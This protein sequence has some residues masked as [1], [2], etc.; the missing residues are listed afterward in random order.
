MLIAL[1]L[2]FAV[3]S[4]GEEPA[5]SALPFQKYLPPE[6]RL[7]FDQAVAR[8]LAQ[9]PT[10]LNAALEV[11]RSSALVEQARAT[12]FPTLFG[13]GT[14]TRLDHDRSLPG[15]T[16]EETRILVAKDQLSANSPLGVPLLAPQRWAQWKRA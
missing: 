16:P 14:Y 12:S 10:T 7:S 1:I 3:T 6:K 15:A 9:N 2:A 5:S 11:R 8:A 13:N 4:W